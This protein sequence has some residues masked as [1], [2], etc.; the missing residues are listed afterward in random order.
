MAQHGRRSSY[1]QPFEFVHVPACSP[2]RRT[3]QCLDQE[4]N[5]APY[6]VALTDYC[7]VFLA[8]FISVAPSGEMGTVN[9]AAQ[10]LASFMRAIGPALGGL[11]WALCTRIKAPLHQ[12]L[13]FVVVSIGFLATRLLYSYVDLPPPEEA[14]EEPAEGGPLSEFV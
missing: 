10:T 7:C 3:S 12:A 2:P 8:Q 1:I 4:T 9:G 13:P 14:E 11:T 5:G 6:A